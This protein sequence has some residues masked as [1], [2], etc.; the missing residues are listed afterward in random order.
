[1][2]VKFSKKSL[3]LLTL[4]L[5][6]VCYSQNQ[7]VIDSLLKKSETASLQE[8]AV[9]LNKLAEL[10]L[11]TSPEKAEEYAN[12]ARLISEKT[13]DLFEEAKALKIKSACYLN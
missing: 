13:N 3:L 8:K 7:T 1:M 10:Y 2:I 9:I 4:C 11:K 12:Q 6:V 5:S